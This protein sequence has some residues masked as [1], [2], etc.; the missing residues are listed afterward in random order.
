MFELQPTANR[1]ADAHDGG[2]WRR[3][4][5]KGS[6]EMKKM[7]SLL[8]VLG[9]VLAL[10]PAVQAT[11]VPPFGPGSYRYVFK[12]STVMSNSSTSIAFYNGLIDG[13]G[14][15]E[16]DSDWRAIA[17]TA[18]TNAIDNTGTTATDGLASS[19]DVPIYNA[20]GERVWDGN[21]AM[22][23]GTTTAQGA[24]IFTLAG[25]QPSGGSV[26]DQRV[27]TGTNPDGSGKSGNELGTSSIGRGINRDAHNHLN[28]QQWIDAGNAPDTENYSMY[29]LSGVIT[30]DAPTVATI[31]IGGSSTLITPGDTT[32]STGD[33]TDFGTTSIGGADIVKT[34]SVTNFGTVGTLTL[35]DP[36]TV[37]GGGGRFA[38][39]GLTA[40]NLAPGATAT[41][42]V[43]YTAHSAA[44]SVDDA[45]VS[46]ASDAAENNPYT[47]AITAT[48]TNDGVI[49]TPGDGYTGPYRIAFVTTGEFSATNTIIGPYNTFVSDAATN[50]TE[51]DDLGVEWKCL[52]STSNTS[53]K[54]NTGTDSTGDANDVP[55]YTTTGQLIATNNAD[56]WD[57]DI[58]NPI[59]YDDG[60]AIPA[61]TTGGSIAPAWTGTDSD[62]SSAS[63]TVNG[64]SYLGSGWAG[65]NTAKYIRL[66]RGG[67]TDGN[68]ISGPSEHDGYEQGNRPGG[69]ATLHHFLAVSDV[70][71]PPPPGT[72]LISR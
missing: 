56:L 42:A 30:P 24:I 45:T 58:L 10:A 14:D 1:N 11:P 37:T 3:I 31:A 51:L 41:F 60:T 69:P 63:D 26:D 72:V 48:T 50:V 32:P 52:G 20:K 28:G 16:I 18:S 49:T 22:W 19:G 34:Y 71:V 12:Y 54:I 5:R 40:T 61:N 23:D 67:Y 53:A 21:A 57:G 68:W 6:R 43:T 36:A 65:D 64:G 15:A 17:S 55:I 29:G 13:E 44:R 59:S 39:G 27:W 38:V 62:G 46:L 7:I 25:G 2:A 8:A 66:V 35:I 47:F 9:M 70:I 4:G 33:D